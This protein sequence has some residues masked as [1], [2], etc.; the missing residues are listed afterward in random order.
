M[1]KTCYFAVAYINLFFNTT[2]LMQLKVRGLCINKHQT[3]MQTFKQT[4]LQFKISCSLM[5]NYCLLSVW[6]MREICSITGPVSGS[7]IHCVLFKGFC[8]M[9]SN[10]AKHQKLSVH[11]H[12]NIQQVN[13][14]HQLMIHKTL[15]V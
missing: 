7:F 2:K 9:S 8:S 1:R 12:I 4:W 6:K 10:A 5:P 14:K 3:F 13:K 15:F 11:T